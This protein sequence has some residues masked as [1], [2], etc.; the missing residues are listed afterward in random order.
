VAGVG[1][2]GGDCKGNGEE[3]VLIIESE[4]GLFFNEDLVSYTFED[5]NKSST[6]FSF[7]IF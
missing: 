7:V 3:F 4:L 6:G 1:G 5:F 2:I